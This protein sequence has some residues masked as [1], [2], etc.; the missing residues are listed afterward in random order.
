L[1]HVRHSLAEWH[2]AIFLQINN[3]EIYRPNEFPRKE[4][5]RL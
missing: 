5:F 2:T 3:S 4:K 1:F